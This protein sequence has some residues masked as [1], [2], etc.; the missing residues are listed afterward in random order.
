MMARA[1]VEA[2]LIPTLGIFHRNRYNSYCLAD[3][4][5]E[6]YRPYV[7]LLVDELTDSG[8]RVL[9]LDRETKTAFLSLP[10]REVVINGRRSPMMVAVQLTANSL[11]KCFS[12]ESRKI[13]YPIIS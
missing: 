8:R 12:G 4:M 7:D 13:A 11:Y 2:G 3:D 9:D 10:V 5:M 1:L 6:P